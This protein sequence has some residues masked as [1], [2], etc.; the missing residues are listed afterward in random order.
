MSQLSWKKQS[1]KLLLSL[2]VFVRLKAFMIAWCISNYTICIQ[3]YFIVCSWYSLD[4]WNL[5]FDQKKLKSL[6]EILTEQ[7]QLISIPI[8]TLQKWKRKKRAF[9][10]SSYIVLY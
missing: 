5:G 7:A 2:K 6:N 4:Q 10:C 1:H 8:S 3:M 9:A